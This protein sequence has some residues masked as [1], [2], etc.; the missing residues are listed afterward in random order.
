VLLEILLVGLIGAA[1]GYFAGLGFAQVIGQT[2]FGASIAVAPMVIPLLLV[3]VL[4]VILVGSY[5]SIRFLLS[6]RPAEVL[7]GR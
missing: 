4:L 3:L 7:H 6:L 2:V 1:A 5:P